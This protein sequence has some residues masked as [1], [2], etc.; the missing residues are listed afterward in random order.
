MGIEELLTQIRRCAGTM[1]EKMHFMTDAGEL[2]DWMREHEEFKIINKVE[3]QM[4]LDY[5][6]GHDYRLSTDKEGNLVRVDVNDDQYDTDEYS[7]DDLIDSVCEWNYELILHTTEEMKKSDISDAEY[8]K[9][10][11]K[12]NS[13]KEQ[14]QILDKLFDQTKYAAKVELLATEL[15]EAFVANLQR[16]GVDK[17]V[18]TLC[19]AIRDEPLK[20]GDRGGR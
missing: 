20:E 5:M 17:A 9:L 6:E 15:A 19:E 1:D 18:G 10:E 3:A 13:L 12:M 8:S 11:E 7:V 4:L 14:E 2:L 16:N